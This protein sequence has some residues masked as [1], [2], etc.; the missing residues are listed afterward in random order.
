MLLGLAIGVTIGLLVLPQI[1][2]SRSTY[3]ATLRMSV[4]LETPPARNSA[5]AITSWPA[6]ARLGAMTAPM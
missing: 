5:D 2:S 6:L 1:F 3:V 4:M